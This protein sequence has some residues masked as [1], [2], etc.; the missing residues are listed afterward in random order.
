LVT[1]YLDVPHPCQKTVSAASPETRIP[2]IVDAQAILI[3]SRRPGQ[4]G[5]T[6]TSP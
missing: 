2:A 3:S 1:W 5:C 6:T 4:N